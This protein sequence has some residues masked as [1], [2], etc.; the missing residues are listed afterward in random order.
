MRARA[1]K[2]RLLSGGPTQRL[3]VMAMAPMAMAPV[4]PVHHTG[5]LPRRAV[6]HTPSR[7]RQNAVSTARELLD[8]RAVRA[9]SPA[10]S[11]C[12]AS[13]ASTPT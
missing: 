6:M 1:D 4:R 2:R 12:C 11:G 5:V 13:L 7:G 10:A 3:A 9:P 8:A